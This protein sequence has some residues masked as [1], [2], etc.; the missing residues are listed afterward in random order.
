MRKTFDN[1]AH[2]RLRYPHFQQKVSIG[3]LECQ[4]GGMN[5]HRNNAVFLYLKTSKIN[6]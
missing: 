2:I 3:V 5:N 1:T 6:L 4:N